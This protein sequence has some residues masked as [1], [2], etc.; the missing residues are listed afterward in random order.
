MIFSINKIPTFSFL[1]R[2]NNIQKIFVLSSALYGLLTFGLLTQ[3]VTAADWLILAWKSNINLGILD[4]SINHIS[5]IV[6]PINENTWFC[7]LGFRRYPTLVNQMNTKKRTIIYKLRN[8][9]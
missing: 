8:T 3:K 1:L 9:N 5:D 2:L 7:N 6:S 4:F